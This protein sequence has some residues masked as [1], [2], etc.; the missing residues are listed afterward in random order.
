LSRCASSDAAVRL[1][2]FGMTRDEFN[3][4]PEWR[5]TNAKKKVSLF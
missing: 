4:M 3:K 2:V 5:R 1:Q